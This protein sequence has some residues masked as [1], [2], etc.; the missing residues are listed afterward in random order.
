MELYYFFKLRLIWISYFSVLTR[1]QFLKTFLCF[2]DK[3]LGF[4]DIKYWSNFYVVKDD[5]TNLV[6]AGIGL[7]IL[8]LFVSFFMVPKK[9]WV[10]VVKGDKGNEAEIFIGGRADKFRSL[11]FLSRN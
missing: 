5:G 8:G 11:I 9:I 7:I 1:D 4:Y 3:Y 10:E 6:Y 2:D